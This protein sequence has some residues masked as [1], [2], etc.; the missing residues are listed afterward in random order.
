MYAHLNTQLFQVRWPTELG[1]VPHVAGRPLLPGERSVLPVYD[2]RRGFYSPK[3]AGAQP[4]DGDEAS[5]EIAEN[6]AEEE[7]GAG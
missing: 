3:E 6:A 1:D 2:P 7:A 4:V 5:L